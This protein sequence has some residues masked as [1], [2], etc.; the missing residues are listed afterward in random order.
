MTLR[1]CIKDVYDAACSGPSC[2]LDFLH[3]T[4]NSTN[5][6]EATIHQHTLQGKGLGN[7]EFVNKNYHLEN[8]LH[9]MQDKVASILAQNQLLQEQLLAFN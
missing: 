1:G 5:K 4:G 8:N 3:S 9:E 6:L 7:I 2:W